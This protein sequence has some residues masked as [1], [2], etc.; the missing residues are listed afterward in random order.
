MIENGMVGPAERHT[1]GQRLETVGREAIGG[2]SSQ[3]D[4]GE[5]PAP[6]NKASPL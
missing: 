6:L 5:H 3:A 4:R 1:R 2:L